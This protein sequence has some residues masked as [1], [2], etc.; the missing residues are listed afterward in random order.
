MLI[1]LFAAAVTRRCLLPP[2]LMMLLLLY[3]IITLMRAD[4]ACYDAYC[5][6][7]RCRRHA[8]ASADD[9]CHAMPDA[10]SAYAMLIT[11]PPMLRHTP[12]AMLIV[13]PLRRAMLILFSHAID[14]PL[15]HA[16]ITLRR[17]R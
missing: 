5:F 13:T 8:Y 17:A 6:L 4:G 3:A 7:M 1:L 10:A 16:A 12:Y 14:M 15:R 11:L 2:L 9:A